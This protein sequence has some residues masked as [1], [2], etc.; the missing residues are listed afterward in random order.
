MT[1]SSCTTRSDIWK[2]RVAAKFAKAFYLPT[3]ADSFVSALRKWVNEYE[4]D[5]FPGKLYRHAYP[6][7]LLDRYHSHTVK[8]AVAATHL[9]VLG[10]SGWELRSWVRS[11]EPCR[12]HR[13]RWQAFHL[14]GTVLNH[15]SPCLWSS[16]GCGWAVWATVYEGSEGATTEFARKVKG[17]RWHYQVSE[18]G[19]NYRERAVFWQRKHQDFRLQLR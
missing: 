5:P 13:H 12:F 9:P 4:A 3:R 8:C 1:S 2:P 7:V 10:E 17:D 16:M 11:R 15:C 18:Q 6:E 14:P 19:I